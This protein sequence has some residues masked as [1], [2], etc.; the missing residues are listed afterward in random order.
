MASPELSRRVEKVVGY[1]PLSDMSTSQRREFHEALLD[2][3]FEDLLGKL[4]GG[5]PQG[6]GEPAEA[7]A[8]LRRLVIGRHT[9]REALSDRATSFRGEN[10]WFAVSARAPADPPRL[11][12]QSGSRASSGDD[13][14]LLVRPAGGPAGNRPLSI[15]TA[16]RSAGAPPFRSPDCRRLE[17]PCCF[18]RRS[19]R[20]RRPRAQRLLKSSSPIVASF[21]AKPRQEPA[22][23]AADRLRKSMS[24]D[25]RAYRGGTVAEGIAKA[26]PTAAWVGAKN[27]VFLERSSGTKQERRRSIGSR[28]GSRRTRGRGGAGRTAHLPSY[29]FSSKAAVGTRRPS[30]ALLSRLL[31]GWGR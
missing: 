7:G 17:P 21:G 14:E 25:R 11:T 13:A 9:R 24:R 6:K 12:P 27:S 28:A 30:R 29:R 19:L 8:C 22:Q 2:D 23:Y 31:F 10:P 18:R 15:S 1:P 5:D 16:G 20:P 4:A 3:T 26:P